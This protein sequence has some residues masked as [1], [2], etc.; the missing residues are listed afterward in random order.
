LSPI[1]LGIF[2]D[3]ILRRSRG[4][5]GIWFG[6]LRVASFLFADDVVLLASLSR[7]L[8]CNSAIP[9]Q[10]PEMK[11]GGMRYQGRG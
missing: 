10:R 3:R 1:L 8:Q 11:K 5:D 9:N 7:D 2:V 4:D 6:D